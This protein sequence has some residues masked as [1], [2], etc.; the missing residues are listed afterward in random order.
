M[1][2]PAAGINGCL[3]I[4]AV[5]CLCIAAVY[6]WRNYKLE[7]LI[8]EYQRKA[9]EAAAQEK[10]D[11]NMEP[12][13]FILQ[14]AV[15]SMV[16]MELLA[17]LQA[18]DVT[19]R[20]QDM[21]KEVQAVN[22]SVNIHEFAGIAHAMDAGSIFA[23]INQFVQGAVPLVY[24]AGGIVGE[25]KDAGMTV[26]F[27]ADY[28]KAVSLA[29]SICE[30]LNDFGKQ[31][32]QY[33]Q[34]S[35]GM[36]YE[37]E[38]LGMVGDSR[39]MEFLMLSSQSCGLADWLMDIAVKYYA[40]ILVTD[41]C[42]GLA[43]DFHKKFHTRL[44]GYVY[45]RAAG[46]VQRIYDVFDGDEK[47]IRNRKRQ[48]KLAFEK[49]VQLFSKQDFKKARQYFIEVLKTDQYDRAA[50][51]YV[52]RCEQLSRETGHTGEVYIEYYG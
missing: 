51:E 26:Y 18:E 38:M 2:W 14:S 35:I 46:S 43:A 39:R 49:G 1:E 7:A 20:A 28:G 48:T 33:L 50:K 29:V 30:L 5:V 19:G 16:P 21:Q 15:Q 17:L 45:I 11:R 52:Y 44:L 9:K 36:T 10:P 3:C 47:E 12:Q 23:F 42:A 37:E 22:M 34:F 40:R 4:A 8:L 24:E 41:A 25:F 13:Q 6:L 32:P 27:L 31:T